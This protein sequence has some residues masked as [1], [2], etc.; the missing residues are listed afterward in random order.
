MTVRPLRSTSTLLI[1]SLLLSG[2]AMAQ[3]S[4]NSSGPASGTNVQPSSSIQ[5][6]NTGHSSAGGGGA[7]NAAGAPGVE[8]KPGS[9]SGPDAQDR[10]SQPPR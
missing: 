5:K 10:T 3:Q 9:E 1:V 4:G 8:G 6:E 2:F 7:S